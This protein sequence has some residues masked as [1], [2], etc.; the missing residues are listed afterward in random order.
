M[1]S[2][3]SRNWHVGEWLLVLDT[4]PPD[5]RR[6]VFSEN[7]FEDYEHCMLISRLIGNNTASREED[8]DLIIEQMDWLCSQPSCKLMYEHSNLFTKLL[9]DP[10][11]AITVT[12]N[13]PKEES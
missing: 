12:L 13:K 8:R 6:R 3:V 11:F 1:L 10:A 2:L 4:T 9:A 7:K 5:V